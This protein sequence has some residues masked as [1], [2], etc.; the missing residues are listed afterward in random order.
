MAL[1]KCKSNKKGARQRKRILFYSLMI[2]LPLLQ[3]L[4]F[5]VYVNFSN[6]TMA[7]TQ[8]TAN[9]D[10]IG[11]SSS[12]VWFKNFAT[13]FERIAERTYMVRNSLILF[14]VHLLVGISLVLV[15]SFFIYKE[16]RGHKL[17]RVILFL[18]QVVSGVVFALIFKYLADTVYPDV[19]SKF[20]VEA[21]GL[22]SNKDTNIQFVTVLCYSIFM[23]FG[24][25]VLLFTGSMSGINQS[26]VE[27]AQ[28]D[29][30]NSFQ[31]FLHISVPSVFPTLVSFIL[32]AI[33]GIFTDQ[34]SLYT[35]YGANGAELSTIGYDLFL[36][37]KSASDSA[38]GLIGSPTL[39]S[40]PEL[41]AYGLTITVILFP[42]TML[43]RKLLTKYGPSAD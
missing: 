40:F 28:L 3:F 14:A 34:M 37:S 16:F 41:S 26:L 24:A 2:A 5:Y 13:V 1:T 15:F 7:F 43:V 17:F 9:E 20:G 18:P 27:S 6:I 21:T 22:I 23:G 36:R 25:N 19:M 11:Y 32:I 30:A 38:D 12:F 39:M 31:E 33:A 10:G 4:I 8:Y 29:G 42:I 35:F